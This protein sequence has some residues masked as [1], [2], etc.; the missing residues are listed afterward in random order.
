MNSFEIG[1]NQKCCPGC[2]TPGMRLTSFSFVLLAGY[3]NDYPAWLMLPQNLKLFIHF[4]EQDYN[5]RVAAARRGVSKERSCQMF[6]LFF[7]FF[8]QSFRLPS[9]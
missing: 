3:G 4:E 7:S 6:V 2:F 5:E 1:K 8:V 9:H